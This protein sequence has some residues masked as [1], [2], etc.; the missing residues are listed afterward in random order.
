MEGQSNVRKRNIQQ[1]FFYPCFALIARLSVT[2]GAHLP[3]PMRFKKDAPNFFRLFAYRYNL[4][5]IDFSSFKA[6]V[7]SNMPILMSVLVIWWSN[8]LL[9]QH[10]PEKKDLT[11]VNMVN[12]PSELYRTRMTLKGEFTESGTGS[13]S[14]S[15][16]SKRASKDGNATTT[17]HHFQ[18]LV[19]I[20]ISKKK[21]FPYCKADAFSNHHFINV[22]SLYGFKHSADINDQY[23]IRYL[24]LDTFLEMYLF[25]KEDIYPIFTKKLNE[26]IG[27]APRDGCNVLR[28]LFFSGEKPCN[29]PFAQKIVDNYMELDKAKVPQGI[30]VMKRLLR[31]EA[32][33]AGSPNV[34][35][36][37]KAPTGS[38]VPNSETPPV[39]QGEQVSSAKPGSTS[40]AAINIGQNDDSPT[41]ANF[42]EEGQQVSSAKPGST[43][44]A[45]INLGDN[46]DSPAAGDT[47]DA[48]EET[49]GAA[50]IGHD[51][52]SDQEM[53][54]NDGEGDDGGGKMPATQDST[55]TSAVSGSQ[56]RKSL[57]QRGYGPPTVPASQSS[58]SQ[59]E[60]SAVVA[61]SDSAA[62]ERSSKRQK[63][64]TAETVIENS[65]TTQL[66]EKDSGLAALSLEPTNDAS[67][68][69]NEPAYMTERIPR[70]AVDEVSGETNSAN[71]GDKASESTVNIES[72]NKTI[73]KVGVSGTTTTIGSPKAIDSQLRASPSRNVGRP[74][75]SP[76]RSIDKGGISP[77]KNAHGS[78]I[79]LPLVD[80]DILSITNL[81]VALLNDIKN[82]QFG[83]Q[84]EVWDGYGDQTPVPSDMFKDVFMYLYGTECVKDIDMMFFVEAATVLVENVRVQCANVALY[85][86]HEHP[87][88]K[89]DDD[90]WR[91]YMCRCCKL[92]LSFE[93][94]RS[95]VFDLVKK[96]FTD[97]KQ[98]DNRMITLLCILNVFIFTFDQKDLTYLP[99]NEDAAG[100]ETDC[101]CPSFNY[102]TDR[103]VDSVCQPDSDDNV[104]PSSKSPSEMLTVPTVNRQSSADS[105]D[106]FGFS[107][108]DRIPRT[109]VLMPQLG[110][111]AVAP[112][113]DQ[114]TT[115]GPQLGDHAVAPSVDQNT[116]P[117]TDAELVTAPSDTIVTT[118]ADANAVETS[119]SEKEGTL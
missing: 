78:G 38:Q 85:L 98:S 109:N 31:F 32:T 30:L 102:E 24:R 12:I 15:P 26:V 16:G 53:T 96:I 14:K 49:G 61:N 18:P 81:R 5:G 41:A 56:K 118:S 1:Q 108:G 82:N 92:I 88:L 89:H 94:G 68:P 59:V 62:D 107:P 77:T 51:D 10:D 113:V 87:S 57:P 64:G 13:K 17:I 93:S 110:D 47:G 71:M 101:D 55:V 70:K 91:A 34:E 112:S 74:R 103:Y 27:L 79:S 37:K 21:E 117:G 50:D 116:S 75:S 25:S 80:Q 100:E 7:Y 8:V 45:A 46:D 42:G 105:G 67:G 69:S 9:L 29:P 104:K 63:T 4:S 106:F 35:V 33:D 54:G 58:E 86:L 65:A 99:K 72:P 3:I 2:Y 90:S 73:D 28:E 84:E 39:N 76:S 44:D 60:N 23:T 95:L 20:E 114:N 111:H 36:S 40:D 48:D 115:P 52:S 19:K 43:S 66:S 22:E 119:Q 11:L 83:G 97:W 6:H